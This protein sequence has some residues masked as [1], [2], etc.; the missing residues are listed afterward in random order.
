MMRKRKL[1]YIVLKTSLSD[2]QDKT[3]QKLF[4]MLIKDTLSQIRR[5][6]MEPFIVDQ[7]DK[8]YKSQEPQVYTGYINDN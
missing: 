2:L 3:F 7:V 6:I 1:I 4:A 8:W 5:T